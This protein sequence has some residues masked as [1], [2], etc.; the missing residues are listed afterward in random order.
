MDSMQSSE[1]MPANSVPKRRPRRK[2][3]TMD[4]DGVPKAPKPPKTPKPPKPPKEPNPPKPPKAPRQPRPPKAPKEPKP[5]LDVTY[6]GVIHD[7][8]APTEPPFV[9][10]YDEKLEELVPPKSKGRKS[11]LVKDLALDLEKLVV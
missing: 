2:P 6:A 8:Q 5:E 1:T 9:A 4:V 10:V 3:E 11:V 7:T